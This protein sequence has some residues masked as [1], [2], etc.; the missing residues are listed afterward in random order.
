MNLISY[1]ILRPYSGIRDLAHSAKGTIAT[2][3]HVY[4]SF[5]P[6][7]LMSGP[8]G[9]ASGPRSYKARKVAILLTG[10]TLDG[11]HPQDY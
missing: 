2:I 11:L 5:L 7:N 3:Q 10:A 6:G 9:E 8:W 1:P 4:G